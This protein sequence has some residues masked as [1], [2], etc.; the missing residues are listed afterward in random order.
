VPVDWDRTICLNGEPGEFAT[1]V[2]K[3]R[4]SGDW[5]LGATT[6]ADARSVDVKLDFLDTGRTYT[7][8]IYRDGAGDVGDARFRIAIEKR[9][10]TPADTLTLKMAPGGGEAIRFVAEARDPAGH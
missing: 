7:A 9:T 3:D 2:R 4:H 10:V 8:E 6:N 5:Y 1:I